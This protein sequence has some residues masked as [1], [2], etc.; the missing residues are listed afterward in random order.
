M[1]RTAD[2]RFDHRLLAALLFAAAGTVLALVVVAA[3]GPL[4]GEVWSTR[5]VQKLPGFLEPLADANRAI[6]T[7]WVVLTAGA[8]AAIAFAVRR[9]LWLAAVLAAL[10]VATPV[11]QA[12]IKD[13]VDRP[14]PTEEQVEIR[15]GYTSPSFPAG[16]LMSPSAV[17]GFGGLLLWQT[18]RPALRR[19]AA[20]VGALLLLSCW[21]NVYVGVHWPTDVLGGLLFGG[22]LA[23]A[24]SWFAARPG[25][26]RV[27]QFFGR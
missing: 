24:A 20:A 14:R 22:A 5:Q 7:T 26:V 10:L 19:G 8:V 12:G 6:T 3:D 2:W 9:E 21:A 27:S 1:K 18:G 11:C 4:A 15:S 25:L 13:L 16:H 17:Y 23:F